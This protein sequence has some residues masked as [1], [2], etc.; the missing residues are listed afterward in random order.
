[1]KE[2]LSLALDG[3]PALTGHVDPS[4]DLARGR[5]RLR[6]RRG[7]GAAGVLA[8]VAIGA[9]VPVALHSG[10][11]SAGRPSAA[12][13]A[14]ARP[15]AAVRHGSVAKTVALVAWTGSEPPG[16]SV[17]WMPKGWVVQG[18]DAT[19]LT[20]APAHFHDTSMYSFIGK[21]VVMLQSVDVHGAPSPAPGVTLQPQ[22]VNGHPG[23]Y[24]PATGSSAGLESLTYQLADGR[25]VVVQAPT[26]LG[27]DGA[28]LAK[29]AG[30]VRVLANAHGGHG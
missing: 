14:A 24:S 3:D 22:P 19:V 17:S 1:M 25:W 13:P 12:R 9:I 26:T 27:W 20:I 16:Y 29:F 18:G 11:P 10:G 30:G 6:R 8:A 21:L 15:S 2:L 5:R 4:E 28:E 23:Y 7:A